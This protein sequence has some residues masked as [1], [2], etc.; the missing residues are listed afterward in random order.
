MTK[1]KFDLNNQTLSVV[2]EIGSHM[3]GGFFI[4][5]AQAPEKLIYANKA[6]FNIFGCAAL[7]EFQTYTGFTFKG[8]V[9]PEDYQR[10]TSS[11]AQQIESDSDRMDYTEYRIIR[12]DGEV[13]WV[14][15]YGHYTETKTYGGIYVVFI[16]DIT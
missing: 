14:D 8:M 13:R 1:N 15:D 2:E 9:H 3:P 10:I 4:Y 11:I 7:D 16:S 5:Q 6:V 12:K